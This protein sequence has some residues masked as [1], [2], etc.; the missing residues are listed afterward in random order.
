MVVVPLRTCSL[1]LWGSRCWMYS[2]GLH[3]IFASPQH[4]V[5]NSHPSTRPAD[6]STSSY[7][8]PSDNCCCCSWRT[9]SSMS[10]IGLSSFLEMKCSCWVGGGNS[11]VNLWVLVSWALDSFVWCFPYTKS[12]KTTNSSRSTYVSSQ[13]QKYKEIQS[14]TLVG[15]ESLL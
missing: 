3:S 14:D 13:P 6:Y 5:K 8:S 11:H 2:L 10:S 1:G 7:S 9:Y 15:Q 12:S 4:K